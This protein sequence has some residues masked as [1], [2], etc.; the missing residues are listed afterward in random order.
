MKARLTLFVTDF[1]ATKPCHLNRSI[2][3]LQWQGFSNL[4]ESRIPQI[5]KVSNGPASKR[6]LLNNTSKQLYT[7]DMH[8]VFSKLLLHKCL[9]L[10]V[11][12]STGAKSQTFLFSIASP[13]FKIFLLSFEQVPTRTVLLDSELASV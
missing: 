5:E 3:L 8:A 1:N 2:E 10:R 12:L 13:E 9:L 11:S 7:E 6:Q 4:Y